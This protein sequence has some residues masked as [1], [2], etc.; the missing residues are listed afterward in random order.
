M[1]GVS[2]ESSLDSYNNDTEDLDVVRE[3]RVISDVSYELTSNV[4]ICP[5][6]NIIFQRSSLKVGKYKFLTSKDY[7]I[8]YS[9]ISDDS[10]QI[11]SVPGHG[12]DW[13]AHDLSVAGQA[14]DLDAPDFVG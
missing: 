10:Y 8:E 12:V 14:V 6:F 1:S 5:G 7:Y 2:R 3:F 11:A 9:E 13:D 4:M